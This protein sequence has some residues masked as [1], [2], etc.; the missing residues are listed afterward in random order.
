LIKTIEDYMQPAGEYTVQWDGSDDQ[1]NVI[2]AGIYMI[3]I[4]I[5]A[6]NKIEKVAVIE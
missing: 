4:K 2:E 3:S 5:G 1:G 6:Y